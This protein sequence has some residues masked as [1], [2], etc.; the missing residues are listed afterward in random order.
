MC[1]YLIMLIVQFILRCVYLVL[2][3]Y[4]ERPLPAR[5]PYHDVRYRERKKERGK[6][7]EGL[8]SL[9]SVK[10]TASPT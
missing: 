10:L 6:R 1:V 9:T 3:A 7:K 4:R 5:H 8:Y 2:P